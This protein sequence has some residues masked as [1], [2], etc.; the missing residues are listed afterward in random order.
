MR[1]LPQKSK[2]TKKGLVVKSIFSHMNSRAHVDLTDMQ[3]EVYGENRWIL[4][5]QDHLT[6]FAASTSCI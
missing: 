5:Y 2:V 3:T 1:S 4:V 6:K